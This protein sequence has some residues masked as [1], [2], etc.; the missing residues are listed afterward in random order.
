MKTHQLNILATCECGY[1]GKCNCCEHYNLVFHNQL[2][3]FCEDDLRFFSRNLD[4]EHTLFDAGNVCC[5]GRTIAMRTPMNNFYIM[6]SMDE[7]E[8]LKTM[9][10]DAF[11]MIEVNKVLQY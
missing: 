3:I 1:V 7:L 4:Y 5:N 11:V 8:I 2:F 6:F 10:N 9:L